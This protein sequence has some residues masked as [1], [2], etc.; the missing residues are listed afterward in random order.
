[1]TSG[2]T[3]VGDL[4]VYRDV[5]GD[6]PPLVLLAGGLLTWELTFGT[7]RDALAEVHTTIAVE[8]Q[9][10]GRTA[11]IDREPTLTA[12]ADDVAAVLADLGHER[13]AVF[14][15][16]LGA[17]V[18]LEL[19][20]RSPSVV[21]RLVFASTPY[22]PEGSVDLGPP[23]A[24]PPN[25]RMPTPADFAEME[26][27]YRAV[28]PDPDGFAAFSE[29]MQPTVHE[30][31]GWS[32]DEVRALDIPTLVLLGDTDFVSIEHAAEMVALLPHG[33]LAVLPGATHM[34]ITRRGEQV[35][36]VVRPFLAL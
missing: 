11:D 21:E 29:K 10:H 23:D 9:G 16:S 14:G 12:M 35:L 31:V 20:M 28:A 34:D 26:A 5:V 33:Q 15:F 24:D 4:D 6:G 36:A 22:S 27:A 13:A 8:L 17:M 18:A 30:L 19:A 3:T 7:T 2:Y 32:A 1:M 25:P